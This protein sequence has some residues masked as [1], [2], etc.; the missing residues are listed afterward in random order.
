MQSRA[1]AMQSRAA[2]MQSRAAAMRCNA[3]HRAGLPPG[4]YLSTSVCRD[5]SPLHLRDTSNLSETVHTSRNHKQR[6]IALPV[7]TVHGTLGNVVGSSRAVRVRQN[8]MCRR[9]RHDDEVARLRRHIHLWNPQIFNRSPMKINRSPMEKNG[10]SNGSA[11][12]FNAKLE[13]RTRPS[14]GSSSYGETSAP[15]GR[16]P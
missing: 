8:P 15:S 2:A 1:A 16:S 3:T 12:K 5:P 4:P 7:D 9:L 14:G 6:Q 13:D 10:T 11:R